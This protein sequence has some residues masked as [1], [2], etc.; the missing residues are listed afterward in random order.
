MSRHVCPVCDG[1]QGYPGQG[2]AGEALC[3]GCGCWWLR[4]VRAVQVKFN[5]RR[6]L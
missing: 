2:H 5:P 4:F 3:Y 6:W 1:P